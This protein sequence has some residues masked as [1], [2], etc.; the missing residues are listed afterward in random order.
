MKTKICKKC[1]RLLPLPVSNFFV[2][3]KSTGEIYLSE[4]CKRHHLKKA[5]AK[6]KIPKVGEDLKRRP[7]TEEEK[8]KRRNDDRK[9][10][11]KNSES[12][13]K[14]LERQSKWARKKRR[15]RGLKPRGK[16]TRTGKKR[17]PYKKRLRDTDNPQQHPLG[18]SE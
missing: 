1:S 16:Y 3:I 6:Q 7:R 5:L 4:L 17:G 15:K 13:K 12:R 18:S 9:R 10:L 8:E 2:I 11:E 14:Q